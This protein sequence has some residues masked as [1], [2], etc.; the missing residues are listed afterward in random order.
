M[1]WPPIDFSFDQQDVLF[2]LLVA[3]LDLLAYSKVILSRASKNIKN[4]FQGNDSEEE[5]MD[6]DEDS[7]PRR[8]K[9][10]RDVELPKKKKA[11]AAAAAKVVE[12]KATASKS[13]KKGGLSQLLGKR[14]CATEANEK[15][16]RVVNQVQGI[17]FRLNEVK[18][19]LNQP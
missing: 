1:R 2:L 10:R 6:V 7:P 5:D 15:I 9:S 19:Q 8:K 14:R 16:A 3:P 11:S 17:A 4:V 13:K 12:E 18:S